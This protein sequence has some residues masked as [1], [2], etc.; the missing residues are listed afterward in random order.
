MARTIAEIYDSLNRVKQ[1][2]PELGVY[3]NNDAESLDTAKKLVNDVRTQSRVAIWR[4]WLWIMAVASWM[5]EKLQEKHE[6]KINQLIAIDKPHTLNWYREQCLLFQL[7]YELE[8]DG[9]VFKYPTID[10][11]ARIVKY[12]A[13]TEGDNKIIIKVLK[14]GK[15]PLN[16]QEL[17]AFQAYWR[18]WKDAGVDL[19]FISQPANSLI[20][21][22]EIYRNRNIVNEDNTLVANPDVNVVEAVIDQ[23]AGSM[24]FNGIFDMLEAIQTVKSHPGITNITVSSMHCDNAIYLPDWRLIS[25]SGFVE[26]D[27]QNCTIQYI[28]SYD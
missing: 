12:A 26:V 13:A 10:E 2:M 17:T 1:N 5:V 27:W 23:Y 15:T 9:E 24:N 16:Q 20:F 25:E 4:L 14:E 3:I 22:V 21:A 7:G 19:Q 6:A 28:D 8:W 18:R 11:S